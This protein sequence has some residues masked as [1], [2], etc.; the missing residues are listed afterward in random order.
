M[1]ICIKQTPGL[2]V[3]DQIASRSVAAHIGGRFQEEAAEAKI[4]VSQNV[5]Q[6]EIAGLDV[7]NV[8]RILQELQIEV[9]RR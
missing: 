1:E 3:V 8:E 9:C 7:E 2:V 5:Y 6:V 4:R